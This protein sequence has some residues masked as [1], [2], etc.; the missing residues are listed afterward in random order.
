MSPSATIPVT[1]GAAPSK[2]LHRGTWVLQILLALVFLAAGGAKLAGV[3]MM[4]QVFDQVGFG[5]WFRYV[6]A[7]VE[8]AGAV[9]LLWPGR[10]AFGALLLSA[11]MVGATVAHLLALHSSPAPALVLLGLALAVLYVRRQQ[12][13]R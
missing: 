10:A 13:S 5:Q 4:V 2:W 8:V 1:P 12:L 9:L 11:T 3:P 6:T 7:L